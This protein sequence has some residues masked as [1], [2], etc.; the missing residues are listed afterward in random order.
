VLYVNKAGFSLQFIIC[1]KLKTYKKYS[2]FKTIFLKGK[3]PLYKDICVL[4]TV[5][6]K[7]FL[8][9][10]KEPFLLRKKLVRLINSLIITSIPVIF[11]TKSG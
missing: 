7:V 5:L 10:K 6:T 3:K 8:A 4:V 11:P 9:G 2:D 1:N